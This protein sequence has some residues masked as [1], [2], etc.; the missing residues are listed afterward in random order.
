[1]KGSVRECKSGFRDTSSVNAGRRDLTQEEAAA[2]RSVDRAMLWA[3]MK[4]YI[5][6]RLLIDDIIYYEFS[7]RLLEHVL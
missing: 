2:M 6:R 7:S 3:Y 1:M 4:Q 5:K